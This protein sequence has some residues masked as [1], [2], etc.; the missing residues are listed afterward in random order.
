MPVTRGQSLVT[1]RAYD[2][3]RSRHSVNGVD[4]VFHSQQYL[5]LCTQLADDAVLFEAKEIL[6]SS[7]E[8]AFHKVLRAYMDEYRV[9][10]LDE[11]IRV[12]EEYW[13]FC[14]MGRLRITSAHDSGGRAE[15]S[16]SH[17]DEGWIEKFG[18]RPQPVN[19]ITQGYLAAAFAALYDRPQG[20]YQ[21]AE[22]E[23]IV[24]GAEKSLFAVTG[25]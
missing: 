2:L 25:M 16:R 23:S 17:V 12:I 13:S 21:V 8:G 22:T 4:M 7:A 14:G 15:M 9:R 24:A 5:S 20:A 10:T 6:R 19:F 18:P 1:E 3:I 11:R